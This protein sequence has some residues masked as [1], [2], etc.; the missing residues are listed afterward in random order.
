[1]TF[2]LPQVKTPSWNIPD[3]RNLPTIPTIGCVS[4]NATTQIGEQMG[5]FPDI[6]A[7]PHIK[8]LNKIITEQIGTLLEGKLPD[9]PRSVLYEVRKARLI[10]E[11]ADII[12]KGAQLAG[13]IQAEING[14]IA[15]A[16]EKINDLNAAKD[17][18]LQI[19]ENARSVIQD[20]MISRYNE[21]IGEINA[22]IG[23]LQQSLGCLN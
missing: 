13:Q 21:Y 4:G 20:K 17:A 15:A 10:T 3:V 12:S 11:L 16:N 7:L 6:Q 14:A 2:Q 9:V 19:P 23:R 18:L 5:N 1:M 8:A 22:Q